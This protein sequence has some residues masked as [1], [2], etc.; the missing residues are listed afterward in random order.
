MNRVFI[1]WALGVAAIGPAAAGLIWLVLARWPRVARV[2]MWAGILV[3]HVAAW[4][5][6]WFAYRGDEVIWRGLRPSLLSATLVAAAEVGIL[7]ALL[8]GL[9]LAPR[10]LPTVVLGL[11]VGASALAYGAYADSLLV[12]ALF[13]PVTTLAAAMV[14]LADRERSDV[15]G[16]LSLAAADALIVVGLSVLEARLGTTMVEGDPGGVVPFGLLLGGAA[17]KAGAIPGLGTW[18]LTA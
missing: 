11:T 6:F 18:R 7:A 12:I 13:L 3:A 15:R 4:A 8:R 17:L 1:D 9:A 16:L 14:S 10:R 2:A 5:V